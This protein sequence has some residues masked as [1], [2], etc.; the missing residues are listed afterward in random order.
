MKPVSAESSLQRNSAAQWFIWEWKDHLFT[1]EIS[2]VVK[3][4]ERAQVFSVP[5]TGARVLGLIYYQEEAVPVIHPDL[6]PG[7]KQEADKSQILPQL[8][9]LIEWDQNK[10]GIPVDRVIRIVEDSE[11]VECQEDFSD[12]SGFPVQ[13][14]GTYQGR[15]LYQLDG[16]R[17]LASLIQT[18]EL[19]SKIGPLAATDKGERDEQKDIAR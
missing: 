19:E 17:V 1:I 10:I 16:E 8:I 5:L 4:I 3:V 18:A 6:L 12:T 9:L 7:Y 13:A 11:I 14:L 2:R 15:A